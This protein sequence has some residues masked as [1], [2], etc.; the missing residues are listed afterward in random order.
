L[1]I[2]SCVAGVFILLGMFCFF[3]PERVAELGV[4]LDSLGRARSREILKRYGHWTRWTGRIIGGIFIIVG[5]VI[6]FASRG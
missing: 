6:F 3:M 1:E 5:L 2:A 4:R